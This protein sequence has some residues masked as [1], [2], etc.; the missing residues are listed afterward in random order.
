MKINQ[1]KAID[2][3]LGIPICILLTLFNKIW[4]F[5]KF[6]KR[7]DKVK[8][9]LVMKYFGI[10]SILLATPAFRALRKSFPD[11]NITF[12]TFSSNEEICNILK[13]ADDYIYLPTKDFSAFFFRTLRALWKIRKEQFDISVDMEFFSKFSTIINYLSSAQR[14]VGFYSRQMW[15]GDLL[16]DHIY[17]NHHR[18]IIDI[19]LALFSPLGIESNDKEIDKIKPSDR[20]KKYIKELLKSEG[21]TENNLIIGVNINSSDMCYER[22]WPEE[23]FRKL[24]SELINSHNAKIIMIGGEEDK[25]YVEKTVKELNFKDSILN[26]AGKLNLAGLIALLD[27]IK[28]FITNDSGP[29]HL[30]VSLGT[31]TVS[32]FGPETPSLYGHYSS[33]DKHI[34]FY[35]GIYCSPCLSVYNVKTAVCNGDNQCLKKITFKEVYE[36]IVKKYLCHE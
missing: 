2:K 31:P 4:I 16:T 33:D 15:R 27:E 29:F 11:A 23:N 32:F 1:M 26:L 35:K 25:D 8:K 5:P 20:E 28:L 9:I 12:L 19:F 14:R 30:A 13:I 7:K 24:I 34:I 36:T 18:H 17:Y 10:G 21:F 3:W 22:R 6:R